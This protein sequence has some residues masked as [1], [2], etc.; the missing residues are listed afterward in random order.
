MAGDWIKMRGNLWDHP[1]VARICDMTGQGEA[2][3]IGGLYYLWALAD[4]HTADGVLDGLSPGRIDR[5]VAIKGFSDA[6][7][8]VGWLSTDGE[9]V[10]IPD[11]EEHNGSS[12][13]KRSQ[14]AKRAAVH[15]SAN[16]TD[17]QESQDGR[18]GATQ[19]SAES[20]AHSVTGA[21][22][23]EEKR[24][25]EE[26]GE[27][28]ASPVASESL[29]TVPARVV[30]RLPVCQL[31]AVVEVF[32]EVLPE[33]PA[34]RVM[35]GDRERAIRKRWQWVVSSKRADGSARASTQGEALAWFRRF[36]E[37]ARENDFVMGRAPRGAGHEGW[38]P[39]LDYLLSD[40]GLRQVI[41]K[42]EVA[43]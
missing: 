35:T 10:V 27:A 25:E 16:A 31:Q 15:R 21:L 42:T 17:A 12:A 7:V 9:S 41:E 19:D 38:K 8:A 32:H 4:Q 23:R 39:D 40:K 6:L 24:R 18:A 26:R 14:T 30:D 22:P 37:L 29:P 43:A 34:C 33:L 2:A 3:V 11:F 1:K 5:K 28:K 20:N 36:F 13:K